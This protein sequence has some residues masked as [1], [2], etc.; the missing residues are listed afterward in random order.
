M[1]KLSR[2]EVFKASAMTL[3]GVGSVVTGEKSEG[4]TRG[5]G[6]RAVQYGKAQHDYPKGWIMVAMGKDWF[7]HDGYFRSHVQVYCP[8]PIKRGQTLIWHPDGDITGGD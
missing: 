4:S 2:R 5:A 3:V 1:K 8:T 6:T 7:T